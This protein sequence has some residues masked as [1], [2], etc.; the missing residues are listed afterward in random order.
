[1]DTNPVVMSE[2]PSAK[3]AVIAP[4]V[5]CPG[6]PFSLRAGVLAFPLTSAFQAIIALGHQQSVSGWET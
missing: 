1:M 6:S 4:L 3:Q 5:T 2:I